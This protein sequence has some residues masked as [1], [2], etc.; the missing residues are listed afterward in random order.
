LALQRK[1]VGQF[2]IDAIDISEP[3]FW[4]YVALM[5]KANNI[6]PRSR[7]LQIGDL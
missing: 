1:I 3:T 7:E 2:F 6:K 5:R 4:K